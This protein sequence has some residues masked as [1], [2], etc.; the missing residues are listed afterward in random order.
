MHN[1]KLQSLHNKTQ[2]VPIAD[3]PYNMTNVLLQPDE[4]ATL[5]AEHGLEGV[6]FNNINLY[7][8]AFVHRSYCSMKNA[9]F[10]KANER[11]PPGCL[12][13]Q[14][15]SYER[16]EFLGDAIL[17][18]IVARYLFERY[19]DQNEGFLS[20]MRTK[21][22]NGKMLG[23]LAQKMGL[24]RWVIVSKQIEETGGR[25]NYKI[26]EDCFEA[27]IAAVYLDFQRDEDAPTMPKHIGKQLDVLS[28][29]GFYVAETWVVSIMEKHIDFVDLIQSH[30]NYKDMLTRWMQNMSQDAPR[31]F[32]VSVNKKSNSTANV[33][34][35][36][37]KDRAGTVLGTARG[38]SRK[39]A[40]NNASKAAL[41][42]YGQSVDD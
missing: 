30:T 38:T 37:V 5:F 17:G 2:E 26:L 27:F 16:L 19:P 13:L 32:E 8:N 18:M 22:V 3:M 6:A 29:S 23:S 40:E 21:I 7:R 42:Y 4:L 25:T 28:G 10:D 9:D 39:D 20:Q 41:Q 15:M 11:L 31:Y 14:D 34:T 33:F 1:S 12:P 24:G 36:C 35:Y